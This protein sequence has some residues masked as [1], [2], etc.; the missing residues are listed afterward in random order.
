MVV[1]GEDV[2]KVVSFGGHEQGAGSVMASEQVAVAFFQGKQA[3][4]GG[5]DLAA[6][7]PIVQWGGEDDDVAGPDGGIDFVH[8]VLL[9]AG[10]GFAAMAAKAAFAAV[11]GQ[12]IQEKFGDGVAGFFSSL[13]EGFYQGRGVASFSGTAV[14][15][16]DFFVHYKLPLNCEID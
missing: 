1:V 2:C 7:V 12:G 4:N 8:V 11:D 3:V 9:D 16:D 5:S 10:A 14:Q 13:G 6:H 15:D